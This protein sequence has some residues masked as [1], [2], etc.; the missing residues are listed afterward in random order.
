MRVGID[1]CFVVPSRDAAIVDG[2]ACEGTPTFGTATVTA[3]EGTGF[4]ATCDVGFGVFAGR[5][6]ALPGAAPYAV[7]ISS[8]VNPVHARTRSASAAL[9]ACTSAAVLDSGALPSLTCVTDVGPASATVAD[10]PEGSSAGTPT[11][12]RRPFCAAFG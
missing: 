9:I 6:G 2:T 1:T 7:G 4:D 8:C 12:V 5:G 11:I 10:F 3:C